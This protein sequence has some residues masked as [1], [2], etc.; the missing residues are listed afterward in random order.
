MYFGKQN[1]LIKSK[2]RYFIFIGNGY[3]F[4]LLYK[5]THDEKHLRRARQ[6]ATFMQTPEFKTHSRV[7]DAPYSLFEGIAG[8]ACFSADL[9]NPNEGYDGHFPFLDVF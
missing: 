7:P 1:N 4:L 9:V 3:V 2:M 6:F 5:V 8:T